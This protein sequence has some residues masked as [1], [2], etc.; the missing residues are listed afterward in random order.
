M[1]CNTIDVCTFTSSSYR[2][3][4][5]QPR[6]NLSS[7]PYIIGLTGGIASGKSAISNHLQTHGCGYIN[8]DVIGHKMYEVGS[9]GCEFIK[10]TF[11]LSVLNEDGS[12]NR[13]Q[14]GSIVFNNQVIISISLA[15]VFPPTSFDVSNT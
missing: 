15:L 9:V 3:L 13:G 8:C 14:L 11:G 4:P 10:E 5:F 7:K 12:V 1:L 6:P 2:L